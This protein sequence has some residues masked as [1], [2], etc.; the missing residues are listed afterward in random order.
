MLQ[1]KNAGFDG[2]AGSKTVHVLTRV[3]LTLPARGR[4]LV[5]GPSGSGKTALL[6]LISGREQPSRGEILLDGESTHRWNDARRSAWRRRVASASED[7][8][9]PDRTL[10]QNAELSLRLAGWR[11]REMRQKAQEALAALGLGELS[12]S[13]PDELSG[14]ERRL[15]ALCYT[16]RCRE[17][18]ERCG[19]QP[20]L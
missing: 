17:P 5:T 2:A 10:L 6:R 13:L 1:L 11:G 7:L 16:T 14:E 12:G 20:E 9:L 3:N 4:V 15:G 8:L 19:I 18:C